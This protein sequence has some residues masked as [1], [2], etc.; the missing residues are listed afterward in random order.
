MC[1]DLI[2]KVFLRM[3][4]KYLHAYEWKTTKGK[5]ENSHS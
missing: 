1:V 4:L 3:S 2:I 5:V